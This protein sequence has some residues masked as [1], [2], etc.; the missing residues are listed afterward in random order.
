MTAYRKTPPVWLMGLPNATLGLNTGIIFFVIPQLLAAGHVSE[1][2]IAGIT[3]AAMSSN[4]SSIL[5]GPM[6]DV[7]FSRRWYATTFAA[8]A[9]VLGVVSILNLLHLVVL[10]IALVAGVA[11]GMLSSTALGG[12]LST[13]SRDEDKN[14][15]SAWLNIAVICG[16]G[17]A[18]IV[19]GELVRQLPVGLAAGLVGTMLFLPA[20]IF[21]FIPA[22]GPDRRLAAESFG[23]FSREVLALLRR[24]EVLLALVLF[25]SPCSSFAL[26][27]ILG[28][29]GGD[30]HASA[31]VVG[32]AGGAGAFFPGLI[33]C[34][35]FPVLARKM[36][37]RY[38]Y[39]VNGLVGCLFSLA[40]I[41]LPHAPWTFALALL[42][43][44]LFQAV[45]FS[46]QVGIAFETIGKNNPL[47]AT[48]FTFLTAATNVPV[49]YM[50][51]ADGWGYTRG[52]V[53]GSL[54]VDGG[55]GVVACLL[56][57]LLLY[58]LPGEGLGREACDTRMLHPV[59]QRD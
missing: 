2:R 6:L 5:L 58:R 40:L 26:P 7:R 43:E 50:M 25:I 19:G 8:L 37:L 57:C 30:F 45:A 33:G 36:P 9:A 52:G 21:L 17:V 55:L 59:A 11:A 13:V 4:F 28:G 49:T 27:D 12:W 20:T 14:K 1:I 53:A 44:Y 42:G 46:I 24:R 39:L 16:I 56:L 3:A 51:L 29:L 22:P 41:L 31:R 23:Q 35:L 38:F 32:L 54:A 34:L 10:E 48:T 15:L 47:A 18:S